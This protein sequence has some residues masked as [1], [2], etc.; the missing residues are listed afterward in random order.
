MMT[1]CR[2]GATDLIVLRSRLTKPLMMR[3]RMM[4]RS[5]FPRGHW[6]F[7]FPGSWG[8]E[9]DCGWLHCDIVSV[10]WPYD[11][12]ICYNIIVVFVNMCKTLPKQKYR[13]DRIQRNGSLKW[14]F[15]IALIAFFTKQTIKKT[16]HIFAVV[17]KAINKHWAGKPHIACGYCF[18]SCQKR[19]CSS[20][21]NKDREGLS[22]Y[23]LRDH[24]E[25]KRDRPFDLQPDFIL[26]LCSRL[27]LTQKHARVRLGPKQ[28]WKH[29]WSSAYMNV[30]S[31]GKAWLSQ[32]EW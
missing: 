4:R 2:G 7:F 31:K 17:T 15:I 25:L 11:G 27:L 30:K 9:G 1:P 29:L 22:L 23:L 3:R 20:L 18:A 8:V 26:T 21:Q 12:I 24:S 6:S 13:R 10:S 16:K 28:V 5:T 14:I 32:S 19:A